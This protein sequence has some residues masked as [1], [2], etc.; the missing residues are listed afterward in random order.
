MGKSHSTGIRIQREFWSSGAHTVAR[1][2]GRFVRVSR[3]TGKEST[4]EMYDNIYDKHL[5]TNINDTYL[6]VIT[7]RDGGGGKAKPHTV[8]SDVHIDLG[9]QHSKERKRFYRTVKELFTKYKL[10]LTHLKLLATYD[11]HLGIRLQ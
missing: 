2:S 7:A 10:K 8:F 9:T 11:N 5:S 3:W 6:Y 1:D 4:A